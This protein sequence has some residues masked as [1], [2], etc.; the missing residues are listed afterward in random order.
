[1]RKLTDWITSYL[2]Y[3][4]DCEAPTKFHE[5]CAI[6]VL[7]SALE[8]TCKLVWGSLVFYPN[9]YI[10]LVAPSGKARKSTSMAH[11]RKFMS[12]IGVRLSSEATTR[13]KLICR[14]EEATDSI[15]GESGIPLV[16]SSMTILSS[17][18]TVFLGYNNYVLMSD[19]TDWYDCHD[20][21]KY[22]TKG[23][24]SNII[25]GVYVNLL[26]GTTPSLIQSALPLD[27][28]G[29]GLTSRM[30]IVFEYSRR[31]KKPFPFFP[32]SDE[33]KKLYAALMNDLT[34]IK[35]LVGKFKATK[36]MMNTYYDWYDQMP[37][38]CPFDVKYFSGYWSRRANHVMKLSMICSASR[39]ND[40]II[41]KEDLL[42]AITLLEET[43]KKMPSAFRGVGRSDLAQTT[44]AILTEIVRRGE[45]T[46]SEL[47]SCFYSDVTAWEL[48]R[49]IATL[50]AMK[51][52]DVIVDMARPSLKIIRYKGRKE[53]DESN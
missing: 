22:E 26:G 46:T 13:E 7:A 41:D 8:R 23:K 6:S 1:M 28:I 39:S 33:G 38:D 20:E 37:E 21:W 24:G 44:E 40:M 11:A 49:I 50:N 14:M 36:E 51:A 18:L 12:N 9:F 16:H 2:E 25:T 47:L 10:V 31:F 32:N 30:I 27:A 15:M 45:V 4:Q 53:E 42:R 34:Q 35:S 5:W 3:T 29:G 43:E 17:E 52:I 19:L 48:D